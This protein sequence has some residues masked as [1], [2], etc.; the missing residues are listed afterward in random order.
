MLRAADSPS[1][2]MRFQAPL[3]LHDGDK[4]WAMPSAKEAKNAKTE[5]LR[6]LLA[7]IFAD[8]AI[9]VTVVGDIT[10]DKAVQSVATTF[11][12][13]APRAGTRPV[14]RGEKSVSFPAGHDLA[15]KIGGNKGTGQE[16]ISLVWPT[17]GRFP[18][19]KEDAA[20]DL[21]SDIMQQRLFER[22]RGLGIVYEADV[23]NTSSTVFDF[24]YVQAL[25][26]LSPEDSP[27]FFATVNE[28]AKDIS[29]G[30]LTDDDLERA[31]NPALQEM[32]KESGTNG[33]W[34]EALDN[35][36]E[37]PGELDLARNYLVALQEVT[38]VDVVAAAREY[39][40]ESRAV[41]LTVG[42]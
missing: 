5:Q 10:T 13:F 4:R 20:L 12:A 8:G 15:I 14:A 36:Q 40:S 42:P 26:Q 16:I 27:K 35:A 41:R 1:A 29:G 28:I 2:A 7:P 30:N 6:S 21:M 39:L 25:A 9:D 38:K 31:K 37:N 17:R 24:G 3:L 11:G 34:L 22:L 32:R 18:N 23:E 19:I 33:Y